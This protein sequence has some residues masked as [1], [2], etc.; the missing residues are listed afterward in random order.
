MSD[1]TSL[2]DLERGDVSNQADAARMQDILKDI[3]AP[4]AASGP[5]GGMP[6]MP[7]SPGPMWMQQPP[8]YDPRAF[9]QQPQQRQQYVPVDEEEEVKPRARKSNIWSSILDRLRDPLVVGLLV[10]ILIF[11]ALH[12]QLAKYASWA[13]A[14]GGQLNYIG[15]G[16]IS[17]LAALIFGIYKAVSDLLL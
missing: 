16:A 6:S 1:G 13:Y 14:V 5:M 10:L 9:Q 17:L 8:M 15:L 12:T 2:E 7:Q 4:S 3:D 11:P